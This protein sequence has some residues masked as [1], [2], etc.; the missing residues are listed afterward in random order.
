MAGQADWVMDDGIC[1]TNIFACL[2][3]LISAGSGEQDAA[4]PLNG[5]HDL[6]YLLDEALWRASKAYVPAK[7]FY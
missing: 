5:R 7:S 4:Q 1:L 3:F 2:F 6:A